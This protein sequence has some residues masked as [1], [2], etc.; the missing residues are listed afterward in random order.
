VGTRQGNHMPIL[1]WQDRPI[2]V[3]ASPH[4]RLTFLADT[5]TTHLIL[6]T[7][8]P[9]DTPLSNRL[10]DISIDDQ[11]HGSLLASLVQR[12]DTLLA[13]FKAYQAHLQEHKKTKDVEARIFRRGVESEAKTLRLLSSRG[14]HDDHDEGPPASEENAKRR[15]HVFRSSNLPFYEAIWKSAKSAQGVRALGKRVYWDA[16]G[17]S[18]SQRNTS[19]P[20]NTKNALVDLVSDDGLRWTKVSIVTEKR[21]LFDMAKQG[22]EGYLDS[23]SDEN[24][25][26]ENGASSIDSDRAGKLELVRLAEQLNQAATT[27]RI[28]YRHPTIRFILPR[29]IEGSQKEVDAMIADIRATGAVVECG[30]R[31]E[32]KIDGNASSFFDEMLPSVYAPPLTSTLNIDCTILLALISDISHYTR[33]QLPPP[34]ACRSGHYHTAIVKQIEAEQQSR[35]LPNEVYP[36]LDGKDLVCTDLAAQRMVEIANTMGTSNERTRAEIITGK[37]EFSNQ[38][39]ISLKR[40]FDRYSSFSLPDSIRLPI[41]IIPFN[42]TSITSI[43]TTSSSSPSPSF[44]LSVATHLIKSLRLSPINA[45][46]FMYGWHHDIVTIT[47]NRVVANQIEKSIDAI[48]D[49]EEREGRSVDGFE[50]PKLWICESARSLV[51]KDKPNGIRP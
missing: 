11:D 5:G 13:E 4:H 27:V 36:V 32:N 29:I 44:P 23:D 9:D 12:A 37:G 46:V 7:M 31:D 8:S 6:C 3:A 30:P 40:A 43:T 26:D 35:L 19:A 18:S 39:P 49:A 25:D 45:S 28:R 14:R 22:W 33:D 42:I 24:S 47:S 51:G 16:E 48:L 41:K 34:P 38:D 10:K 50:G 1:W 2:G 21:L 20:P 15:L 17:R